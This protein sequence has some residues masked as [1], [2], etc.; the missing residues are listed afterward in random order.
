[1]S[2]ALDVVVGMSGG[3]DS[4]VAAALLV[5]GGCRV[6]GVTMR[7]WDGPQ[8]SAPGRH[9]CYGPGE[10]QDI[11]DA[12]RVALQL[13][14]P[15]HVVDVSSQYRS[16]VLDYFRSEYRAGRTPNPCSRCNPLIKFGALVHKVREYGIKFD[17]FA[18]GHYARVEYRQS[19]Q[20]FLLKKATDIGKDQSY[21]LALLSRE[22]V[23]RSLFPLGGYSKTEVRGLAASFGLPVAAKRESQDFVDQ[24]YDGLLE[25]GSP[26]PILDRQGKE[27]GRHT[28]I[29]HHTIGQR[30][31]LGVASDKP[32]YVTGLDPVRNAVVVGDRAETSSGGLIASNLNWIAIDDLEGTI[33]V[34][35]RIRSRHQETKATVTPI[36]G[37]RALVRFEVPQ[38][39]VAPGQTVVFYDGD[40]VVGGGTIDTVKEK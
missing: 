16:A 18:T 40:I 26:G 27:L 32:L 23:A 29:E 21:F 2:G 22:Q 10:E 28:G 11:D 8:S 14:I 3:V 13:G 38:L 25:P 9:G 5:K 17:H 20:R 35:V 33:E 37:Q 12:R 6:V 7:L 34:G 15:F 24:D 1:M 4:A 31:G 39:A 30:R 36:E 19:D